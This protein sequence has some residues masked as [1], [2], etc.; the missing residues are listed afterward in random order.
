MNL[1]YNIFILE[2]M[3]FEDQ[4]SLRK[5]LKK[6]NIHELTYNKYWYYYK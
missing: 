3:E 5:S 1:S 4:K 6:S 2:N